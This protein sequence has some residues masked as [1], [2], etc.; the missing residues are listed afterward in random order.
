MDC[1]AEI[2][3]FEGAMVFCGRPPRVNLV[4]QLCEACCER[5]EEVRRYR[6]SLTIR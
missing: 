2:E 4:G 6:L 3:D 1:K 5:R